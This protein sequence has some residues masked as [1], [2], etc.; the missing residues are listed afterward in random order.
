M[1][2][3]ILDNAGKF[4]TDMYMYTDN[5]M[6]KRLLLGKDKEI[7][8]LFD[9][10]KLPIIID[11]AK[12][13]SI[14]S[15]FITNMHSLIDESD[16]EILADKIVEYNLVDN[17]DIM[18]STGGF[19]KNTLVNTAD[20]FKKT[21]LISFLDYKMI[22]YTENYIPML[23]NY[24]AL[25]FVILRPLNKRRELYKLN[26]EK[27]EVDYTKSFK[28]LQVDIEKALNELN[29]EASSVY[30]CSNIEQLRNYLRRKSKKIFNDK[31]IFYDRFKDRINQIRHKYITYKSKPGMSILGYKDAESKNM[32]LAITMENGRPINICN[33]DDSKFYEIWLDMP[34]FQLYEHVE[35]VN[36]IIDDL[37][38]SSIKIDNHKDIRSG[39]DDIKTIFKVVRVLRD[40]NSD[41]H[42]KYLYKRL[43]FIVKELFDNQIYCN[44]I[45]FD[46]I[47]LAIPKHIEV[48]NAKEIIFNIL[49]KYEYYQHVYRIVYGDAN[50]VGLLL[51]KEPKGAVEII[52]PQKYWN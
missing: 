36:R 35:L 42:F 34:F 51:R 5:D 37:K 22:G 8:D 14:K 19:N 38:V 47:K 15:L 13:L 10:S 41:K 9:I 39:N 33:I 7:L 29:M 44:A 49:K 26:K 45:E 17:I 24:M 18:Y 27:A 31:D 11:K 25:N 16:V 46:S 40:K 12:S 2:Y 23:L 21:P 52:N 30:S 3:I 43:Y 20:N 28:E 50:K 1:A 4:Y 48:D 6:N 32:D